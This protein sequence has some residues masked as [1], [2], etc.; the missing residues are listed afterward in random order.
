MTT[1][2]DIDWP[3][4]L[5][6]RLT[7]AHPDMLRELLS[8]YPYPD[9]WR[10]PTRCGEPGTAN[11]ALSAAINATATDIANSIR[12]QDHWIWRCPSCG[13]DRIFRIGR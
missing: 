13:T 4:V 12:G 3:A 1:A 8:M 9:G 6:E 5:A 11:A 7:T 10:R 2:Y